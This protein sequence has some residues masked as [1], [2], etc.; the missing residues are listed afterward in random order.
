ML[1]IHSLLLIIVIRV[2]S[3]LSTTPVDHVVVVNSSTVFECNSD[4]S[5]IWYFRRTDQR[6]D[7]RIYAAGQFGDSR[8]SLN[9]SS[10]DSYGLVISDVQLSD[11]GLYTC[12][13][14]DGFG[15]VAS[16]RLVVL[17][18]LQPTCGAN[19][20]DNE[21]LF[22]SQSVELRCMFIY[23][24]NPPPRVRWASLNTAIINSSIA[25]TAETEADLTAV[26]LESWIVV[27]AAAEGVGPYRFTVTIFDDDDEDKVTESTTT[28]M[29]LWNSST[30]VVLYSVRDVIINKSVDENVLARGEMLQCHADGFP[31]ARYKWRNVRTNRTIIGADLR[32]GAEGQHTY[33]CTAT[34]VVANVTYS[35][36]ARISLLVIGSPTT[37]KSTI[38]ST[39]SVVTAVIIATV[40]TAVVVVLVVCSVMFIYRL[41]ANRRRGQPC[42]QRVTWWS[43][44]STDS[45]AVVTHQQVRVSPP[46]AAA[47]MLRDV[48]NNRRKQD[49]VSSLY[50]SINE[51]DVGYEQ[52]P[53]GRLSR[54]QQSAA[55]SPG[56][57]VQPTRPLCCDTVDSKN[58]VR[59]S[60]RRTLTENDYL[61]VCD[62]ESDGETGQG[63]CCPQGQSNDSDVRYVQPQQ[64]AH[65]DRLYV[66]DNL[67]SLPAGFAAGF[68]DEGVY[69]HTLSDC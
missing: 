34:N 29:Y 47:A 38:K 12:I 18:S 26:R 66:N 16:A 36:R 13:D 51:Q 45:A 49:V 67:S 22:E 54:I 3:C 56:A 27:T 31:P 62:G 28:P 25:L 23:A 2:T 55:A 44:S 53:D 52:L 1:L 19:V 30:F 42:S 35:E 59:D 60:P 37:E 14:N 10:D 57:G 61:Y 33:E 6:D 46:Q 68:V 40:T 9:R 4:Q 63:V 24:G 41:F 65:D 5:V 32:L 20:S 50:D 64:P 58:A 8:Y 21:P 69:I 7:T 39:G 48:D 11:S 43:S 15:P 17:E